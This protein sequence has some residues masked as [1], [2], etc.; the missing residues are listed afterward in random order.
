MCKPISVLSFD[1]AEQY[2]TVHSCGPDL[3]SDFF[4]HAECVNRD[5]KKRQ[6]NFC[7]LIF[8]NR[9]LKGTYVPFADVNVNLRN[10][11]SRFYSNDFL[12]MLLKHSNFNGQIQTVFNNMGC[13][14]VTKKIYL[15]C[16]QKLQH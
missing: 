5:R 1:Q 16:N 14:H 2:T 9:Q 7:L 10:H 13:K 3:S 4:A 6:I 8:D 11:S 15:K 12:K